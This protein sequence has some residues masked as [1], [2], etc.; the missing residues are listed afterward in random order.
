MVPT[1]LVVLAGK[2]H[3]RRSKASCW[4][5]AIQW[6]AN[7]FHSAFRS[8]ARQVHLA[9]LSSL[10]SRTT[11]FSS[12]GLGR[13]KGE[14]CRDKAETASCHSPRKGMNPDHQPPSLDDSSQQNIDT[15]SLV[16]RM[17]DRC[18]RHLYSSEEVHEST[19]DTAQYSSGVI[20][21]VTSCMCGR[22][23]TDTPG[24]GLTLL[25]PLT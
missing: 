10:L 12:A 14:A 6:R 22:S 4:L 21:N 5:A 23:S 15:Q 7:F 25:Y 16:S 18:L 11:S 20:C 9:L 13:D 24:A 3:Q 8:A 19:N 1:V 17:P 2:C